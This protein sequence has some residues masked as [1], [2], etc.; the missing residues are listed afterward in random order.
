MVIQIDSNHVHQYVFDIDRSRIAA[1]K[2]AHAC[3]SS[4]ERAGLLITVHTSFHDVFEDLL[5]RHLD[6][7]QDTNCSASCIV[8]GIVLE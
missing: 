1:Y 4:R 7:E 8:H 5:C 6:C 2:Q 3:H